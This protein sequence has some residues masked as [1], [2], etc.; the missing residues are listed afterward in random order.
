MLIS[1]SESANLFALI[2]I[3]EFMNCYLLQ[4]LQQ[5]EKIL[6]C[7][8]MLQAPGECEGRTKDDEYIF[9]D[10]FVVFV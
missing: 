2:F 8:T 6:R 10:V 5:V 7:K 3:G 1:H 4:K 9:K